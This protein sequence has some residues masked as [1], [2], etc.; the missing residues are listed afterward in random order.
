FWN[1]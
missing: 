1:T